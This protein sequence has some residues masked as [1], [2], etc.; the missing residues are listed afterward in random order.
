MVKA[1]LR[2]V[3]NPHLRTN[4]K[5]IG[6]LNGKHTESEDFLTPYI[7]ERKG[8]STLT[9]YKKYVWVM[10]SLTEYFYE[11]EA[12]DD[13]VEDLCGRMRQVSYSPLSL[14][15]LGDMSDVEITGVMNI[16]LPL[17]RKIYYGS[18]SNVMSG[19]KIE[20]ILFERYKNPN[21]IVFKPVLK[22][23]LNEE[24]DVLKEYR[25]HL[26]NPIGTIAQYFRYPSEDNGTSYMIPI[27]LSEDRLADVRSKIKMEDLVSYTLL[28]TS[29]MPFHVLEDWVTEHDYN[30][31]TALSFI[32]TV[33][34]DEEIV[35]IKNQVVYKEPE[36]IFW[37]IRDRGLVKEDEGW[38]VLRIPE[39]QLAEEGLR[40]FIE[41][42]TR[43]QFRYQ[44]TYRRP[45]EVI[46]K[47][48][49]RSEYVFGFDAKEWL[50]HARK[51]IYDELPPIATIEGRWNFLSQLRLSAEDL[52]KV[53]YAAFR[54]YSKVLEENDLLADFTSLITVNPDF[55]VSVPAYD[56]EEVQTIKEE[57]EAILS[58]PEL[59]RV[60][61][62]K[63][64]ES[65]V[66]ARIKTST[67]IPNSI[68]FSMIIGDQHLLVS[69]SKH[70][71]AKPKE[72]EDILK[73]IEPFDPS[74]QGFYNFGSAKGSVEHIPPP[75]EIEKGFIQV[76]ESDGR[77]YASV[78]LR[79]K[80]SI[81]TIDLIDIQAPQDKKTAPSME[82]DHFMEAVEDLWRSGWFL[83]NW[84]R[85]IYRKRGEISTH[86][87]SDIASLKINT[88]E[89]FLK[90]L[91]VDQL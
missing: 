12:E 35:V 81:K 91:E 26:P 78:A 44:T 13:V 55:S 34:P 66:A 75:I 84:G 39:V 88:F 27:Y 45:N 20:R 2:W 73:D 83:T 87:L 47:A 32:K 33:G 8:R 22:Q 58:S 82:I 76:A 90:N 16:L 67:E 30:I 18:A 49:L 11:I 25:T 37:D 68:P 61:I 52:A 48:P 43:F 21:Y 85:N 14:S 71:L 65:C 19:T 63:D 60:T 36:S 56:L 23:L 17:I 62:C 40:L 31:E 59:I 42:A 54:G 77:W 57:M 70:A 28:A 38:F 7:V 79:E 10:G 80:G 50:I 6:Y 69:N 9:V 4:Q 29:P 72:Y 64:L 51:N 89:E 5:L 86:F 53:A 74:V 46:F 1:T 3:T 41:I 15:Y 24:Y